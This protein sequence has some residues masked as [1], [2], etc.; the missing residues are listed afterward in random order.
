MFKTNSFLVFFLVTFSVTVL[1]A[2]QIDGKMLT[3]DRIYSDEF[4]PEVAPVIQRID[5]GEAYIIIE[6]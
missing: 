5:N 4:H 1:Q 2:Q 3:V 6:K